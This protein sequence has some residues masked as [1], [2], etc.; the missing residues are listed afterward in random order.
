VTI[1]ANIQYMKTQYLVLFFGLFTLHAKAQIGIGTVSP[2]STLDLRGSFAPIYRSFTGATGLTTSDHTL[3]FAG[4]SATTATLPDATTCPGRV[5][6]IKNFSST[7]PTP[8]LTL[9]TVSSQQIDGLASWLLNQTGQSV[10]VISDGNNW[11]VFDQYLPA[12]AGSYWSQGG[13]NVTGVTTLGTTSAYDLPFITNNTEKMRIT[14]AG[15]VGIGSTSFSANPEALLVYQNNATSFNVIGGKG[16]LNNYL[17]LNIQN[18]N[19]GSNASSDVVATADNGN[20]TTNY[21]DLGMN[22]STYNTSSI[23][24]GADNAYLYSSA[25]DFVV[26]NSTAGKNLIFFTGG[27]AATNEA[28]R[29]NGTGNIGIGNINPAYKLDVNGAIH[30]GTGSSSTGSLLFSNSTN[31]NTATITSGV[32]TSTYTLTLPTSQGATNTVLFNDGAGNL[33]WNTVAGAA[34]AWVTTGNAGTNPAANFLGTTD[35]QS[36]VFK[37][38]NQLAGK[39]DLTLNNATFGYQ[40]GQAAT[41]NN[42]TFIGYQSGYA[43]TTGLSNTSVGS[44]AMV[45]NIGGGNNTALGYGALKA[46][47]TGASNTAVGAAAGVTN[48]TGADNTFIGNGADAT[49]NNLNNAAAIGYNAKAAVSNSLILGATG[50]SAPNVGVGVNTF[51]ANPEAL[52]VYQNSSTSFNVIGGKGSLNNY[53]QLNIQNQNSGANASSDVVATADNG[54]ETTNYVDLGMNSSGYSTSGITGGAD[55]AYLYSAANDFVIGNSTAAKNLIFFT[56]GTATTNE[57]MR[58]AGTGY[59]GMGTTTPGNKLE[60]NSGTGG[61]SGLRLKELPSGAVLFMSSTNDVAQNNNNF[62]FDAVNYRLSVAAGSTPASTLQV[63]GS[64]GTAIVTKTANYTASGN[65]YTILCNNTTGAIQISLPTATGCAGRIYVIK[66]ISPAGNAV[67]IAGYNGTEAIDGNTTY[68][69]VTQYSNL[70]IQSDGTSWWIL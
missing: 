60:I 19:S 30:T 59:I 62:Y 15:S 23:T 18:L 1:N 68:S 2:N 21:V 55:N 24:G 69:L 50:S 7:L 31:A 63:G 9:A 13:N 53:L 5:Y 28:M 66:K 52:L 70:M 11:E 65:D 20:E 33:S 12:A 41:G 27:A 43:N 64:V 49:A 10:M 36:L 39:I 45:A 37:A 40:A 35:N 67:T 3:L 17:Q 26:G 56:G 61:A 14:S 34:G 46:N 25:N 47:T 16:N 57:A 6:I 51:S 48:S 38:N 22:S 8:V 54:N 32:T 42:N 58:I 29:I 4:T 44:N